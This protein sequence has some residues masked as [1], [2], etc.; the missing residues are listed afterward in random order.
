MGGITWATRST[1]HLAYI[2]T[3]SVLVDGREIPSTP[4]VHSHEDD[5]CP[6]LHRPEDNRYTVIS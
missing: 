5:R 3:R 2:E 4:V 6:H 1:C